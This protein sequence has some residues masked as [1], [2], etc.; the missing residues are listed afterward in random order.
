MNKAFPH[1]TQGAGY[2]QLSKLPLNQGIK[3]KKWLSNNSLMKLRKDNRVIED[4]IQFSEYEYW[5]DSFNNEKNKESEF[6]F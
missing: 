5:F 6:D 4:C 2:I 1:I 3:L